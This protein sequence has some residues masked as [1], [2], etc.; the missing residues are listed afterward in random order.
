[1]IVLFV[2]YLAAWFD[3]KLSV[4]ELSLLFDSPIMATIHKRISFG[5]LFFILLSALFEKWFDF[6]V[7]ALGYTTIDQL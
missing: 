1:L 7:F 3:T 2:N 5:V 6:S 4:F